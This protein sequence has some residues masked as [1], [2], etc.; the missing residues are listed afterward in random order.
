MRKVDENRAQN[1]IKKHRGNRRWM[2]FALCVSIFTGTVTL[3]LLNKPATAMTEDGAK[4]VGLVLETADDDFEMGLIEQMNADKAAAQED[5]QVTESSDEI[6]T[7]DVSELGSE[8]AATETSKTWEEIIEVIPE[9]ETGADASISASSE[10]ASDA[11]SYVSSDEE[12]TDASTNA[13][14]EEGKIVKKINA[15]D[16]KDVVLTAR[17]IDA[18]GQEIADSYEYLIESEDGKADLTKEAKEIEKYFYLNATIDS[19]KVVSLE[20]KTA[21]AELITDDQEDLDENAQTDTAAAFSVSTDEEETLEDSLTY[22]YYVAKTS[23]GQEIEIE[24]DTDLVFNYVAGNTKE[25]FVYQN[26]EVTVTVKLSK[27]GILPEGAELSVKTLD[28]ETEGYN[29]AAYIDALNE[30]ANKI[31]AANGAAEA[32]EYTDNNTVLFDIAFMYEDIEYEPKDG[33][34][35]VSISFNNKQLSDGL[36]TEN[37]DEV[38]LVHLPVAEEIMQELD[39][40]S[41]ATDITS[42]DISV[43]IFKEAEVELL[44]NKDVVS[45]ETESFSVYAAIKYTDDGRSWVG[46]QEYR[47]KEIIKGLGDA[48]YFGVVA[49]TYNG[50]NNHSEANIAVREITNIQNFTIGISTKVFYSLDEYKITVYKVVDGSPKEATFK[51]AMYSDPDGKNR[52]PGTEFSI[53]TDANGKG[54]YTADYGELLKTGK[55]PRLYVFELNENDEAVMEGGLAGKYEVSYGGNSAEAPSDTVGSFADNYVETVGLGSYTAEY[56][57]QKVDGATI[58]YPT[59]GN[60]YV[61]VTYHQNQVYGRK[62]DGTY[63]WTNYVYTEYT[64]KVMPVSASGMRNTAGELSKNLVYAANYADVEVVNIVATKEY[65]DLQ[66]DLSTIYFK[67]AKDPN[68]YAVNTG[69]KL[70][71]NKLIVINVDLTGTK[72][73]TLNKFTYNGEG[74]GDWSQAANHVVINLVEKDSSGNYVPFKG[75]VNTDI[76][77]GTL[78]AP[79][80]TIN[81]YGSYSGTI[82]ANR[83]NKYCEIHKMDLRSYLDSS[84][85]FEITN[86][87]LENHPF[88]I[89]AYKYVDNQEPDPNQVFSFTLRYYQA[90]ADHWATIDSNIQNVGD[91]IKYTVTNPADSPFYMLYGADQ[92]YYFLLTE[93][94]T[95]K[96]YEKDESGILVKVKFYPKKNASDVVEKEI[97]EI[98][99]YRL[100][101]DEVSNAIK[102]NPSGYANN[103]HRMNAQ[104]ESKIGHP[105][106]KEAFYNISKNATMLRIHKM[107]VNDF[108]SGFVRDATGTALLSNVKF[109]ITN[110]ETQDYIVFTGFTGRAN[111]KGVATEYDGKTHQETG[112]KY[113]V[114]YNQ[115]AQWTIEGL[116]A[117]T[118]TVD[119]VA[120]GLTFTYDPN[121]NTSTVI[122]NEHHLYRVTKYDVTIDGDANSSSYGTGGNNL[123]KV[124]SRDLYGKRDE[125][126][127]DVKVGSGAIQ[128]VQVCNYY[129]IPVGPIQVTKNFSGGKWPEGQSFTF[130]IEGYGYISYNSEGQEID[131]AV[132][133]A[134]PMPERTE[135]SVSSANAQFD[136]TTGQYTAIVD[137]GSIPFKYE[138][139]YYYKITEQNTGV[140]GVKYDSTTYYLKVHVTKKYTQFNKTYKYSN[141]TLPES[142]HNPTGNSEETVTVVEDFWYL[143]ADITYATDGSFTNQVGQCEL[144]LGIGPDTS[145]QFLNDFGQIWTIGAL[146]DIAFNNSLVGNLTVSKQWLDQDGNENSASHTSLTLYIWQRVVGTKKWKLYEGTTIQLSAT[147]NWTQT[148]ENLPLTDEKGRQYEYCVKEPD[149]YLSTFHVTY[150]YQGVAVDGNAQKKIKVGSDS[151]RDTGYVMNLGNDNS[152]GSVTITNKAIS[153]YALPSTGGVGTIPFATSGILMITLAFIGM[154]LVNKRKKTII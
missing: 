105:S 24:E 32:I 122:D 63:G 120:D 86:K 54:Q 11:S 131:T 29:Y 12:S 28:K 81:V 78:I 152:Y 1:Y 134:Q 14:S 92:V 34:V 117:G 46:N 104:N 37:S 38:A 99:Y 148:V 125:A 3:Y 114:T 35:S 75:T 53:T 72:N 27:P 101:K 85:T 9:D 31:A 144:Y 43:E 62:A 121:T 79:D 71:E 123:R 20:K 15:E 111:S 73:Y 110:N 17:F 133:G 33:S 116:K 126:P 96:D 39:A 138:G 100:S 41:D 142:Y 89:V 69:F 22:T 68:N 55:Y 23:D 98:C 107:V 2:A 128:T 16:V 139:W 109:R 145:L 149:E 153:T 10:D 97:E 127:S 112:K 94:D 108:G 61:G 4:Q 93:N 141:M 5:T 64:G 124:F 13:S 90:W 19:K 115:S 60:S 7:L 91:T 137:F 135:V 40:T 52:I 45:F 58:Y 83:V 67:D 77:S 26:D 47:A 146:K 129:S 151:Q 51:F 76:L 50:G 49:D 6:V 30:N 42:S 25:E 8:D 36:G 147:N 150:T 59:S 65:G 103:A 84:A 154:L 140:N 130:N 136:A 118:Y 113:D 132:L 18:Q 74:T 44:D 143:G 102:G 70:D 48:T 88:E 21:K 82:I 119:E 87:G 80:A 106:G 57:L 56:V 95:S 66:T